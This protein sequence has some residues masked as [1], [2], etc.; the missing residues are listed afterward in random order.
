MD[1]TQVA[2]DK[3]SYSISLGIGTADA[4]SVTAVVGKILLQDMEESGL[5]MVKAAQG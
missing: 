1:Q 2:E 4:K 5:G 3:N